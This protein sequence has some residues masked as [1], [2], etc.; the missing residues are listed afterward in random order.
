MTDFDRSAFAR[1][2]AISVNFALD[3]IEAD[4]RRELDS[5]DVVTSETLKRLL[6][7]VKRRRLPD[8]A[9]SQCNSTH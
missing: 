7:S 8:E 9:A 1:A 4:I 2:A 6:A 5:G 3:T